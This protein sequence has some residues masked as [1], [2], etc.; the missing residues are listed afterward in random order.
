MLCNVFETHY[1]FRG[2]KL[3][4]LVRLQKTSV[5]NYRGKL[6]QLTTADFRISSVVNYRE[7]F[8]SFNSVF[9]SPLMCEHQFSLNCVIQ[10]LSLHT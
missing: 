4:P 2:M 9:Q 6:Q 3:Q 10:T 7:A 1:R 8:R 5:V